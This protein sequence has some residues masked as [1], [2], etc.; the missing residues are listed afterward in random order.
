MTKEIKPLGLRRVDIILALR[1][2]L[3]PLIVILLIFAAFRLYGIYPFGRGS[4]SWGD[5]SQQIVPLLNQ[6]KELSPPFYSLRAG[7]GMNMYG[8]F[9]YYLASPFTLL[10]RFVRSEDMHLFAGVLV[11]LK[12]SVSALTASICFADCRKKLGA[13][14]AVLLSVMYPFCGF[15]LLY[16]QI[17]PWLD[18]MYLFPLLIMS[19]ER[20][21]SGRGG[22]RMY[23]AVMTAGMVLQ[24]YLCA[25][26]AVFV[27]LFSGV[28]SVMCLKKPSG[29]KSREELYCIT[30]RL[31][32]GSAVSALLTGIIWLPSFM[33]LLKSAKTE[34]RL[35]DVL[36]KSEMVP[37]LPTM[38]PLL[39]CSAFASAV[40]VS[41]ILAK[42]RRSRASHIMLVMLVLTTVP[43][44]LEPINKL[45]HF[46]NYVCFPGRFAFMTCFMLIYCC[47]DALAKRRFFRRS[48]VAAAVWGLAVT[49]ALMICL[50]HSHNVRTE[51]ENDISRYTR[52]LWGD[53]RS[54]GLLLGIFLLT[55]LC[56]GIVYAGYRRGAFP[57]V[58]FIVLAG[59]VFV[60][61]TFGN[62][63]VYMGS[64]AVRNERVNDSRA[65]AY[66]LSGKIAD[67]GFYRVK[68][69]G[70][71]YDNNFI[72]A[73]GY[74]TLC[75]YTS[76][77]DGDTAA[78]LR[79]MGYSAVGM[80]VSAVGGTRLTDALMSVRYEINGGV[81]GGKVVCRDENG[82]IVQLPDYL[83]SGLL[84]DTDALTGLDEIPFDSDRIGVQE[85]IDSLLGGGAVIRYEPQEFFP[86]VDGVY[87]LPAGTVLH[88][89][90]AVPQNAGDI[91]LY[92]DCFNGMS[93][94]FSEDF[95]GSTE[96][97][98][99]GA[100][101]GIFPSATNNSTVC[102]GD[103]N[104]DTVI[105]LRLLKNVS[106]RSFG[107]FGI[108]AD[109]LSAQLAKAKTVGLT[110]GENCILSG[111]CELSAP[112]TCLLGIPY[113]E[114]LTVKVNGH[115]VPCR[116]VLS[117]LT[118]FELDPG[119]NDIVVEF[120]PPG[121]WA[122]AMLTAAG[123]MLFAATRFMK[124]GSGRY[125]ALC[126]TL[127]T[128]GSAAVFVIVYIM[129]L[130]ITVFF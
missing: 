125:G 65:A 113:S 68:S 121:F 96:I 36:A 5:M 42:R 39:M 99:N 129:P 18:M 117:G 52:T 103:V 83:P 37:N 58:V 70:K 84:L 8:V 41:D 3:P 7:G 102:L 93:T 67:D 16:Y 23:T 44:F 87:Y 57:R 24:Y 69:V 130:V 6:Y 127:M 32:K 79:L 50:K 15:A 63:G 106:V 45:W 54:F 2:A 74:N 35:F 88:Y 109:R 56:F 12:M 61:E 120:T 78:L 9:F 53:Q 49:A 31:M 46:G 128:A 20:L 17:L 123:L 92:F 55:F 91:T 28:Y 104:G 76:L 13:P 122:G 114:G 30:G 124:K 86:C 34:T 27:L 75:H 51:Q 112:Q 98:V 21:Y 38:L 71:L 89:N 72:G 85:I 48:S 47:S 108:D 110:E 107:V 62:I 43:F 94:R 118:A 90:A 11:A 66:S 77:T 64:P 1:L 40:L 105:E 119:K 10:A 19:L 116:R 126:W 26:L 80:E 81:S 60:V 97:S 25:M 100:K 33:Q 29:R 82:F 115:S 14:E 111:G 59:A 101:L 4:V 95:F 73:M 22:G